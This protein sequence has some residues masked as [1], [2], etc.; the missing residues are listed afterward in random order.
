MKRLLIVEEALRSARNGHWY[1]TI[2]TIVRAAP[3]QDVAPT[4]LAHARATFDI[5]ERLGAL[6]VIPRSAWEDKSIPQAWR[7]YIGVFRH[8]IRLYRVVAKFLTRNEPFD[9]VFAPTIL[10]HHVLAWLGVAYRFRGTKFGRLTLLFLNAPGSYDAA[11]AL[12]FPRSSLL[13]KYAL[14]SF[15]RLVAS[16][17][18]VLAA[19]TARTARHLEQFC[20]VMFS[21]AAQPIEPSHLPRRQDR[22]FVTFGSFGFARH[23]QGTDLLLEAIHVLL[24]QNPKLPLRFIIRWKEN[25]TTPT[26]AI[27]KPDLNLSRLGIV[28]YL[29]PAPSTEEY[30]AHFARA[31]AVILPYR[32]QS[33][34][35]RGSRV[36]A[37]AVLAGLP[38]ICTQGTWLEKLVTRC[39][40]GTIVADGDVND[41][42]RAIKEIATNLDAFKNQAYSKIAM[43]ADYFSPESYIDRLIDGTSAQLDGK[44]L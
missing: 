13:L 2:R 38:V 39:G 34:R 41:L 7:R 32:L 20:G 14:R 42:A 31:D 25:F 11:G 30:L 12:H 37:E 29:G 40:S 24:R 5:T 28:E 10:V 4:I 22:S 19:E 23:E 26:G 16:G 18:V 33:Y 8:N 36:A 15:R 21:V 3:K 9:A 44:A 43:A 1:D 17:R 6:P 27:V 35:D